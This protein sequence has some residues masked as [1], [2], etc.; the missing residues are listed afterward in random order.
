MQVTIGDT[1]QPPLALSPE[2]RDYTFPVS[3]GDFSDGG[4][5]VIIDAPDLPPPGDAR[6]LGIPLDRVELRDA[7]ATGLIMPPLRTLARRAAGDHWQ[8]MRP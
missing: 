7:G 1:P 6:D 3:P 8:H 5:R 4:T 2:M